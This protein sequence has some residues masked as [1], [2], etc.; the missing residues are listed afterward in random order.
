MSNGGTASLDPYPIDR[1]RW[2]HS[3]KTALACLTGYLFAKAIHLQA[4]QWIVI[5]TLVVMCAQVNVGS[6]LQKSYMRLLGTLSG[7]ALAIITLAIFPNNP[8]ATACVIV[9]AAACFSFIATSETNFS[10]SGTLGAVT[11]T[12]ILIGQNPSIATGLERC[13]EIIL[14]IIIAALI[15]QFVL[16]I[17]ARNHLRRTQATT[18]RQLKIYYEHTLMNKPNIIQAQD[19]LNLDE[20][21]VKS[22]ILQRRLA[23]DAKRE[24]L[25]LKFNIE[26]FKNA[27]WCEKEILRCITFM[28][29]SS[30]SLTTSKKIFP[31]LTALKEFHFSI[32]NRLDE[33]AD[34]IE[35]D[36]PATI[37]FSNFDNLSSAFTNI[38]TDLSKDERISLDAFLFCAEVL[39]KRLD[40]LISLNNK[41][42]ASYSR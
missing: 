10:D 21:I 32:C 20:N 6:V 41:I 33:I 40:K 23:N 5:T 24:K 3:F 12:I 19:L 27:L 4:S 1:E 35:N 30:E 37:E 16:P 28:Y 17:H 42:D 38:R 25:G 9:L 36:K 29:Q 7:A 18:L 14:G 13:L 2:I 34:S 8:F 15:S 11:V 31:D 39:V 26:Y 22:L